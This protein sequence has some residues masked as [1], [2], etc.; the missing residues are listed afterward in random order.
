[1]EQHGQSTYVRPG[2]PLDEA[3]SAFYERISVPVLTDLELDFGGLAVY[4][5][6]PDPLP[7]LFS[8]SQV[9]VVGRYRGGGEYQLTMRGKVNDREQS[10]RFPGQ[11]FAAD[12][13]GESGNVDMLPRLWAT[14]KIGYLLNRIRL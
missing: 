6:Y 11:R 14:R 9:I 8:G 3:L 10:F 4:D 12:S 7:D 13:R 2:E 5:V 1:Q